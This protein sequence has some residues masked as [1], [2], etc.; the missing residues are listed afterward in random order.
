MPWISADAPSMTGSPPC[1][2]FAVLRENDDDATSPRSVAAACAGSLAAIMALTTATPSRRRPEGLADW[3]ST[4]RTLAALMPPMQTVL[5]VDAVGVPRASVS[6]TMAWRTRRTPAVPMMD[7]AF[8]FLRLPPVSG[9]NGA[10]FSFTTPQSL[11]AVVPR[12][13]DEQKWGR[14][15]KVS[16]VGVANT[17][18]IPR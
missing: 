10:C 6:S 18:P 4:E 2:L 14:D 8:V 17:V 16:H 7:L 5:V 9:K 11:S 13:S 1:V 3:A 12:D 15:K